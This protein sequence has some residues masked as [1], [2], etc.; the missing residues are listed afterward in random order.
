MMS[1]SYCS[2]SLALHKLTR[3]KVLMAEHIII[4]D[5][6]DV[7][8]NLVPEWEVRFLRRW[9]DAATTRLPF[10]KWTDWDLTARYHPSWKA[11]LMAMLDEP[12]FYDDLEPVEGALNGVRDLRE[13][14]YRVV[15]ATTTTERCAHVKRKWLER[16][17][18]MPT[19]IGHYPDDYIEIKDKSLL[20]GVLILDDRP[21]TVQR[22]VDADWYPR[23][24][25][26]MHSRACMQQ[27]ERKPDIHYT[28][29]WAG[30]LQ[31]AS[32]FMEFKLT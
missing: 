32:N 23:Y 11:P 16:Y 15:F 22:F 21:A 30:A 31:I 10:E 2:P 27:F 4:V 8:I 14:G 5:V 12:G 29:N 3:H 9:P 13:M 18:A 20:R 26:L 17:L 28:S 6:D 25:I 19:S 24:G 7:M 1:L